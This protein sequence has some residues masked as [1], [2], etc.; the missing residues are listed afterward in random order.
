MFHLVFLLTAG[1][2][3]LKFP[4]VKVQIKDLQDTEESLVG[5]IAFYE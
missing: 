2:G 5:T 4:K 1:S 3:Q